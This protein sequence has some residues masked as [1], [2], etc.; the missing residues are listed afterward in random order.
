MSYNEFG[1]LMR[2]TSLYVEVVKC[3]LEDA[4][5]VEDV[6]AYAFPDPYAPGRFT[7]A[8]AGT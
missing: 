3:P 7:A 6:E 8:R 4:S 5:S 1:M 2:P